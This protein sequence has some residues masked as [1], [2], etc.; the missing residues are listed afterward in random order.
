MIAC[1]PGCLTGNLSACLFICL[2]ACLSACLYAPRSQKRIKTSSVWTPCTLLSSTRVSLLVCPVSILP[3]AL[4][5]HALASEHA[6]LVLKR[7]LIFEYVRECAGLD[8]AA[9]RASSGNMN[10]LPAS[11][12]STPAHSPMLSQQANGR[13]KGRGQAGRAGRGR[14][15]GTATSPA[16]SPPVSIPHILRPLPR[17]KNK[18]VGFTIT[19]NTLV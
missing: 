15:Q 12:A 17:Y 19:L 6:G 7:H 9:Q 3:A 10:H 13:G 4:F 2:S 8:Q 14:G 16:P 5:V 18:L 11:D 1:Q